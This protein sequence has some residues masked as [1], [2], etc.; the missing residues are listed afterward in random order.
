MVWQQEQSRLREAGELAAWNI[1]RRKLKTLNRVKLI[2]SRAE[3]YTHY[4]CLTPPEF[5]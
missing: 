5:S 4:A 3:I 2:V 1:Y